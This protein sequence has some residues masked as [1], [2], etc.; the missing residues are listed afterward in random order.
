MMRSAKFGGFVNGDCCSLNVICIFFTVI[1]NHQLSPPNK[2]TGAL[3]GSR[4][5]HCGRRQ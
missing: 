3:Q 2:K 1:I 4:K 5:L